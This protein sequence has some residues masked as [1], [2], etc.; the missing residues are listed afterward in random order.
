MDYFLFIQNVNSKENNIII[1]NRDYYISNI[2]KYLENY[3]C[4][5][6]KLSIFISILLLFKFRNYN[7]IEYSE[8]INSLL[9]DFIK[10][11]ENYFI[12]KEMINLEGQEIF[13]EF[14]RKI[15]LEIQSNEAFRII[16]CDQKNYIQLDLIKSLENIDKE[17]QL[18]NEHNKENISSNQNNN[19]S[20]TKNSISKDLNQNKE[21][22]KLSKNGKK[23]MNK[24]DKVLIEVKIPKI[25]EKS[26][27]PNK[28]NKEDTNKNDK[29]KEKQ[30]APK[31][32][33]IKKDNNDDVEMK[34][35]D[36][37]YKTFDKD[38]D[39]W[40]NIGVLLN[41]IKITK[42][43]LNNYE[44]KLKNI[45]LFCEELKNIKN[46]LE[47]NKN[48]VEESKTNLINMQSILEKEIQSIRIYKQFKN[49]DKIIYNNHLNNSIYFY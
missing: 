39:Y 9:N 21:K 3:L 30:N 46:E 43:E 26:E 24:N 40:E 28:S 45:K 22:D 12:T 13:Y 35:K 25:E 6:D 14:V 44:S 27:L 10:N 31:K 18:Y 11:K 17:E 48:L 5:K 2:T 29:K 37:N 15:E 4:E 7:K 20:Q 23:S 32:I 16:K 38:N 8:L 41:N 36:E 1:K 47:T 33:G 19:S 49:Y 42:Q 34:V